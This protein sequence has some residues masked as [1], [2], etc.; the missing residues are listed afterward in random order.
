ML[1]RQ[2]PEDAERR[3]V[4]WLQDRKIVAHCCAG[5]G[6][7]RGM[8]EVNL[9]RYRGRYAAVWYDEAGN[10]QRRFLGTP[11]RTLAETRRLALAAQLGAAVPAGTLTVAKIF[12]AS[13]I[14][15]T[16]ASRSSASNMRGSG[17]ALTSGT[18]GQPTSPRCRVSA[19]TTWTELGYL[20]NAISFDGLGKR[21][22]GR[23][24]RHNRT[25]AIWRWGKSCI[26][27]SAPKPDPVGLGTLLKEKAR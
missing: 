16:R 25:S 23:L 9:R 20:R 21:H 12:A 22:D 27:R 1:P 13:G 18:S 17:S 4:D 24:L 2:D 10:R 11:D 8:P 7:V 26:F 14:E 6:K 19:G 3:I 5:S 15:R